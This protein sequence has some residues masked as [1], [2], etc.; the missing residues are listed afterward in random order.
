MEPMTQERISWARKQARIVAR[1]IRCRALRGG[2]EAAALVGLWTA[3]RRF[4]A[5]RG[6][7]FKT[8]AVRHVRGA[9]I[10]WLRKVD[11][12]SRTDRRR[13]RRGEFVP[14]QVSMSVISF[15]QTDNY[16]H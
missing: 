3:C 11:H 14:V 15:G 13:V 4:D 8:H 5:A 7:K 9:V 12:L 2:C 6:I 10:D 16:D 1:R